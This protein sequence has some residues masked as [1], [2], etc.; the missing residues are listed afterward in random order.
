[1]LKYE[2][3]QYYLPHLDYWEPH[4]YTDP[5]VVQMTEAGHKNR[6]STVFWY[7]SDCEGGHTAFPDVS[8]SLLAVLSQALM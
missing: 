4:Y 2:V 6:L 7:L 3:G 8:E 1:V 5:E